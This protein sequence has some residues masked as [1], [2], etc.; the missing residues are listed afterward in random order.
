MKLNENELNPTI[1]LS[2]Q[3]NFCDKLHNNRAS[4]HIFHSKSIRLKLKACQLWTLG[5]L[6]ISTVPVERTAIPYTAIPTDLRTNSSQPSENIASILVQHARL[7]SM[8]MFACSKPGKCSACLEL[9][10]RW[11]PHG[12]KVFR[13]AWSWIQS[14][15]HEFHT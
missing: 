15:D 11:C 13:I 7:K 4:Q 9:S 10:D 12:P 3:M 5:C 8:N 14:D 1:Q 6:W 2:F